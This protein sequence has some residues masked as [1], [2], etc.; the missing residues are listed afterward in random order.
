[1]CVAL[2]WS[3][4]GH[5]DVVATGQGKT[6]PTGRVKVIQPLESGV[7][8]TIY[9]QDGQE[10]KAGEHLVD[11]DITFTA[12]DAERL[13]QE[14]A[15]TE[16]DMAR[17][18][19]LHGG[20]V[21]SFN[22]GLAPADSLIEQT[23]F[24]QARDQH[25]AE[26][27]AVRQQLTQKRHELE[28]AEA[29]TTKLA[30]TLPLI[31]ERA[32]SYARLASKGYVAKNQSVSLEEQRL[33][34][35]YD[36]EAQRA[37]VGEAEAAI[38]GI[39]QQVS[40]T[41]AAFQRTAL[42]DL[43]EKSQKRAG[44]VQDLAKAEKLNHL[45]NLTAPIDGT[46]QE[47]KVHTIGGVVTPAQELMKIVPHQDALEAE[48]MI[49]NR[50]I[51]FVHEGQSVRLKFE[52]YPFTKYGVVDGSVTKLSLDAV[53]NDKLGLVY[54]ARVALNRPTMKVGEQ[55]VVLTPGLALTAEIKTGTRRII[56]YFLSPILQT[57][58]E[59]I[60]ER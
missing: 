8:K 15:Q 18:Q 9:V 2:L 10:V 4:L 53:Q 22:A 38:A 24:E 45:Q 23:L 42:S 33:Q 59:A 6:V 26:M 27:A 40:S 25:Q 32:A 60:H 54:L 51:G 41:E 1:M 31:A 21:P 16:A 43:N 13:R 28:E 36:L 50:D 14:L 29:T 3:I 48:V 49:P 34:T 17:L 7:V 35:L 44:L 19:A 58:D 20:T 52:A 47:L 46:V 30:R 11:L 5:V 39:T 55:D 57:S 12:A 56:E 37:K